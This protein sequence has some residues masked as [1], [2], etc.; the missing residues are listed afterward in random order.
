MTPNPDRPATVGGLC[1]LYLADPGARSR[2]RPPRRED[3][4]GPPRLAR[5]L[6]P[7]RRR[8]PAARGPVPRPR[9]AAE[10]LLRGAAGRQADAGVGGRRRLTGVL[11][12]RRSPR[13]SAQP[14]SPGADARGGRPP[15]VRAPP[16]FR[17]LL[18]AALLTGARPQE[19]PGAALVPPEPGQGLDQPCRT[20]RHSNQLDRP[21]RHP[22]DRPPAPPVRPAPPRGARDVLGLRRR[23][24]LPSQPGGAVERPRHL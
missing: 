24:R 1:D 15:A 9:R 23:S 12:L 14:A 20:G 4:A 17:R 16:H 22:P 3:L 5:R 2:P 18:L 10:G 6:H 11:A 7:G 8:R 19:L 13:P 21:A